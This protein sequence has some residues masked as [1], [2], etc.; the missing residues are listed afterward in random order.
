M[1]KEKGV[2]VEI[3]IKTTLYMDINSEKSHT[4]KL[5]IYIYN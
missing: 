1:Y 2:E 4:N 3:I 5:Y